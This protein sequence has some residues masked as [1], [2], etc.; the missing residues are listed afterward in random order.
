MHQKDLENLRLKLTKDYELK[1]KEIEKVHYERMQVTR[2]ETKK[3]FDI[4]LE[5]MKII[6]EDEI[7]VVKAAKRELEEKVNNMKRELVKKEGD[8]QLL[9]ERIR[10]QEKEKN[11]KLEHA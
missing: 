11:L 2:Q 8:I 9:Q 10:S 1:I 7:K 4:T 3:A 5:N 6:Y